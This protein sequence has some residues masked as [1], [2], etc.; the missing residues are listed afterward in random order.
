MWS[1]SPVYKIGS[2]GPQLVG[3]GSWD[4]AGNPRRRRNFNL[5]PPVSSS[6]RSFPSFPTFRDLSFDLR[7]RTPTRS[8]RP[9]GGTDQLDARFMPRVN[10]QSGS[11]WDRPPTRIAHHIDPSFYCRIFLFRSRP[12]ESDLVRPFPTFSLGAKTV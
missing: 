12:S 5:N 7:G 10:V 11:K 8:H 3:G 4:R 2:V 9:L 1:H 6:T